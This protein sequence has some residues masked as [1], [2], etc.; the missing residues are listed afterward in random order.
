MTEEA[1]PM[2]KITITNVS[3]DI[4]QYVKHEK[5]ETKHSLQ[6]KGVKKVSCKLIWNIMDIIN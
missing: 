4:C 6:L 3:H 2:R 1:G 5:C